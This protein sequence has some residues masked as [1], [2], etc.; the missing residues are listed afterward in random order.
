MTLQV[1]CQ[2][3]AAGDRFLFLRL[4]PIRTTAAGR[5]WNR[6]V[7]RLA[8]GPAYACLAVGAL[9]M[10][11]AAA[12]PFVLAL[13]A[14]FAL[15]LPAYKWIKSRTRRPRPCHASLDRINLMPVP[16]EY[17]F[18]SG[19][20]AGA[21]V[22]AGVTLSFFP[23]WALPA[24]LYA[25]MVGYSRVYNRL[26]FPLDLFAGALLGLLCAGA[27]GMLVRLFTEGGLG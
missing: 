24:F 3:C 15:E 8:D 23:A 27:G 16:D 17:S 21:F 14:G 6:G 1:L 19:H 9:W 13:G 12:A 22:L 5:I 25:L 2:R 11:G 10:A 7:S 20:T 4:A 18:P 26:H